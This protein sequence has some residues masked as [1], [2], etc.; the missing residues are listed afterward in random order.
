MD[1]RIER[2]RSIVDQEVQAI[3]AAAARLSDS[4]VQ[5]VEMILGLE[6]R[7]VVTGMGKAGLIAQKASASFASTGTPSIFL[8]PAEAIHGDLGRVGKGDLLLALSKSGETREVVRLI[9]PVKAT[10]VPIAALTESRDSTLGRHAD[11]VLEMG[12]VDEAGTYKLAP[13]AS[14]AAMLAICDALFLVVQ[15]GRNFGPD[16]FARF[17]PGGEIGRKL[18]KV[19]DIMR[20]GE[21]NPVVGSRSTVLQAMEVMSG[22]PGRPGCTS[23]VDGSRRLVGFF[24]DGDLRRLLVSGRG[25]DLDRL[26]IDAVMTKNPKTIPAERLAAEALKILREHHIDQIPV[27]DAAGK[28]LGLVDVQDILD[29]K[30]D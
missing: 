1:K 25:A 4:F 20:R 14:T 12:T 5:I 22:T 27:T 6:G 13:S 21:R 10:G 18:L 30:I 11:V 16:E 7:V 26:P 2:A 29:L 3:Q 8:H 19:E 15:E 17:H 23:V 9:E 28:A 24:T